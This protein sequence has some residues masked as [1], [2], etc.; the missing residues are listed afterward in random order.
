MR[1]INCSFDEAL[2][3]LE[4]QN[5]FD[6]IISFTEKNGNAFIPGANVFF[7]KDTSYGNDGPQN[8]DMK[9]LYGIFEQFELQ[10]DSRILLHCFAGVS[11][12]SA[13]TL[14]FLIQKNVCKTPKDCVDLLFNEI[15][16][17]ASPN[18]WMM[19]WIS[20]YFECPE[21][22]DQIAYNKQNRFTKNLTVPFD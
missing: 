22:I 16:V 15:N 11:R 2:D 12:S 4:S 14:M 10:T 9:R 21:I 7:F 6:L 19:N 13:A 3:Y 17:S 8:E 5:K 20:N 18:K 1:I